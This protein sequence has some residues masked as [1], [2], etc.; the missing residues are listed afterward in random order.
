MLV[1]AF[2][3]ARAAG[4]DRAGRF[5]DIPNDLAV[6]G[7]RNAVL[8]LEV[9]LGHRVLGE[10]GGVRDVTCVDVLS[11]YCVLLLL[12]LHVLLVV[13]MGPGFAFRGWVIGSTYG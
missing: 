13:L 11:V 10:D 6:N 12:H 5:K 8:E 9:H 7:A 1:Q 4:R 3:N 2:A